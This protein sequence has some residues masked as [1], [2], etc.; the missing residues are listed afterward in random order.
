MNNTE[1]SQ[2]WNNLSTT[3]LWQNIDWNGNKSKMSTIRPENDDFKN[4]ISDLYISEN[5]NYI[6]PQKISTTQHFCINL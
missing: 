6:N 1:T 5:V 3:K 2:M 4:H